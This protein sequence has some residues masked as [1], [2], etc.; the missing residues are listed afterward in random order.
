MSARPGFRQLLDEVDMLPIDESARDRVVDL[1]RSAAGQRMRVSIRDIRQR[2][3]SA[4]ALRLLA[5]GNPRAVVV[6]RLVSA[7]GVSNRT[8]WRDVAQAIEQRRPHY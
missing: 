7:C 6:T 4:M 5:Y 8:A 1:L 3:R 2:E